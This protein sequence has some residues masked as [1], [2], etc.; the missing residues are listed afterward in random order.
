MNDCD[1]I[2]QG[3]HNSQSGAQENHTPMPQS[4]TRSGALPMD[5]NKLYFNFTGLLESPDPFKSSALAVENLYNLVTEESDDFLL[6]LVETPQ[7]VWGWVD[8]NVCEDTIHDMQYAFRPIAQVEK[9]NAPAHLPTA[10][11]EIRPVKTEHIEHTFVASDEVERENVSQQFQKVVGGRDAVPQ[12]VP[13]PMWDFLRCTRDVPGAAILTLLAPASELEQTMADSY[14]QPAFQGG[15]NTEWQMWRGVQMVRAR[16][17]LCADIGHIPSRM[18]A[19]RKIMSQRI[20]FAP[21]SGNDRE[22]LRRPGADAMKGFAVPFGVYRSLIALPAA[23]NNKRVPGL[24]S[25][26]PMANIVPLDKAESMPEPFLRLGEAIG[27]DEKRFPVG[28][29]PSDKLLHTQIIGKPGHGKTTLLVNDCVEYATNGVGFMYLDPHGDGTRRVLRDLPLDC[30]AKVRFIDHADTDH[31]VPINPLAA[32]DEASFSRAISLTND[33]L[34]RYIDPDKAG[35]WGERAT[36]IFTLLGTACWHAGI[37][38]LPMIAMIAGSQELCQLLARR[39]RPIKPGLAHAI[40]DE[41]GDLAD[42]DSTEL[43]AWMGSRLGQLL[44]SSALVRILGT[45]ANAFDMGEAMDHGEA[46]LIDL[47]TSQLGSDAVR[48]L[49]G[50]YLIMADLA[51]SRRKHRDRPF[52]CVVDEA[53]TVQIGPLA[54][55]LDEGR[56]FGVFVEAAHQRHNQLES[57]FADAL[58]SDTGTFI[59]LGTGVKDATN[60]SVRLRDWSISDLTR[61]PAFQA[62]AVISRDG[63]DTEPFTMFVDKPKQY[64]GLESIRRAAHVQKIRDESILTLCEPYKELISVSPENVRDILKRPMDFHQSNIRVPSD[65][66]KGDR[67]PMPAHDLNGQEAQADDM[68]NTSPL[69]DQFISD[70]IQQA[71]GKV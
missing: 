40:M 54:S 6:G 16:S 5:P 3:N 2:Q 8:G 20:T 46:L 58:E 47:G 62:A 21:L 22:A 70:K 12:G 66:Q 52:G 10:L 50:C 32:D 35:M 63:S 65:S 53:H 4:S 28:Q 61:L 1:F 71:W 64:E 30:D 27:V 67:D 25:I 45:G 31:V 38:T 15:S 29:S 57:Q 24:A 43:F 11:L 26:K 51:K 23:G 60:A 19:E 7:G 49:E 36:R 18:R 55:L 41:L 9:T 37:A 14:W 17:F 34:R 33:M 69:T 59:C 44:N 42:S 56:K 68:G 13:D 48:V 39:V